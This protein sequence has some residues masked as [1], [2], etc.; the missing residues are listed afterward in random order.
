MGLAQL[1]AAVGESNKNAAAAANQPKGRGTPDYDEVSTLTTWYQQSCIALNT[2][3]FG[4][5]SVVDLPVLRSLLCVLYEIRS[6][7]CL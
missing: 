3:V 6:V 2:V 7:Y 4:R 5:P 1:Q